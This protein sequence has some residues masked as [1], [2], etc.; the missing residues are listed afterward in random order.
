ML[1]NRSQAPHAAAPCQHDWA[2]VTFLSNYQA[3]PPSLVP[4]TQCRLQEQG[5][6]RTQ[7]NA[8]IHSNQRKRSVPAWIKVLSPTTRFL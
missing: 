5:K 3:D 1:G 7:S 4:P 8:W 6:L 2:Y